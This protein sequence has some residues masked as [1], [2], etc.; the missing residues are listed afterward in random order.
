MEIAVRVA[1]YALGAF[2]VGATLLSAVRTVVMPRPEQVRLT[3]VVFLVLRRVFDL[4]TNRASSWEVKDRVMAHFAPIALLSL[5]LVW[6][7]QVLLGYTLMFWAVGVEPLSEA[8]YTSGSSLLTLG[9]DRPN[10]A[11]P[12]VLVFT[13]AALGMA[14]LVLLLV[15]YLPSMYAAFTLREQ[16]V[17]TLEVRAGSPPS[18]VAMLQRYAR[19]RGLGEL[20]V[21]WETWESIFAQL[22]ETHTSLPALA[23]FRSPQPDHSWLTAAGAVL[24][25]AAL[26]VSCIDE[27]EEALYHDGQAVRRPSAEICIRAGF[28]SLNRIADFFGLP[29][30]AEPAPTDPISISRDDFDDALQQ[31]RDAD[32]AVVEDTDEAWRRFAGWRVNYDQALVSLAGLIMAPAAPWSGDRGREYRPRVTRGLGRRASRPSADENEKVGGG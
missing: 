19:I 10:D 22:A 16:A 5:P 29:Y 11:A 18:G 6:L 25:G 23:F 9:F 14:V 13:E 17:S 20:D 26:L 12:I 21:V 27:G 15:T 8:F 28:L 7:T 31:L 1:A 30:A 32:V 4:V 3:G 24:D 2:V